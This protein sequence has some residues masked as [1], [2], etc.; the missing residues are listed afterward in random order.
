MTKTFLM[1]VGAEKAGTT[2]LWC[3]LKN[4]KAVDIDDVVKEFHVW[5][6][7]TIDE[8][9]FSKLVVGSEIITNKYEPTSLQYLQLKMMD[10]PSEYFYYFIRK[11]ENCH[12]TGDFTPQYSALSDDTYNHIIDI[13]AQ[14]DIQTKAIFLMR[15]PVDRLQSLVRMNFIIKRVYQ[16]SYEAEISSMLDHCNSIGNLYTGDYSTIVPKLDRVFK[17]NV[18]YQF[19]ENL[20]QDQ[21]IKDIC[22]FVN[23]PFHQPD[24]SFNPH[25]HPD[26]NP[27]PNKTPNALTEL[28]R[29]H[30]E[31]QY[32]PIY[33]YMLKRFP[34]VKK[35]WTYYQK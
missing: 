14:Y 23:I 11:L 27:H 20:F 10:N 12:I 16:P 13:F 35:L 5:D 4:S 22:N 26:F 1:G 34:E 9:K 2:W 18:H 30:F 33:D 25:Q 21:S 19:Y 7:L 6:V 24:Y 29:Q 32:K 15:D 28:D 8:Y 31:Q 17:S 3:Y